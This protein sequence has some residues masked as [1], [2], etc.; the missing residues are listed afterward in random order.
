M[1]KSTLS[2]TLG[3]D[4]QDLSPY[5]AASPYQAAPQPQEPSSVSQP[6]ST[7]PSCPI[8]SSASTRLKVS[9]PLNTSESREEGDAEENQM[10]KLRKA[11]VFMWRSRLCSDIPIVLTGTFSCK[12]RER[13]CYILITPIHIRLLITALPHPASYLA[14]KQIRNRRGTSHS[15]FPPT[16]LYFT[17]R[18][19]YI[20]TLVFSRR[21]YD[22]DTAFHIMCSASHLA[23][24]MTR[25]KLA[26]SRR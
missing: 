5:C 21:G 10:D 16:S 12:S 7:P 22:I 25:S 14:F 11:L 2:P 19:I 26:S 17:L 15:H 8:K 23:I 3:P 1:G 13:N 6:L 4:L 9:A 20:G 24:D 18:Y